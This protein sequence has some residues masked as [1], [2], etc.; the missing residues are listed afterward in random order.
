MTG[1]KLFEKLMPDDVLLYNWDRWVS[2]LRPSKNLEFI[3][4]DYPETGD[5]RP[6]EM[7]PLENDRSLYYTYSDTEYI[8]GKYQPVKRKIEIESGSYLIFQ[9]TPSFLKLLQS[10]MNVVVPQGNKKW[11][12]SDIQNSNDY[13]IKI[14]LKPPKNKEVSYPLEDL[15]YFFCYFQFLGAWRRK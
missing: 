5:S 9:F 12:C 11:R 4:L 13:I 8:D 2:H 7:L 3:P 14:V 6:G 15:E 1:C 10:E